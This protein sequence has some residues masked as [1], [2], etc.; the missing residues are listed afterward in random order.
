MSG[1][2]NI[3]HLALLKFGIS[4]APQQ[5]D[6]VLKLIKANPAYKDDFE[7]IKSSI[8]TM[9]D[10]N[11]FLDVLIVRVRSSSILILKLQISPKITK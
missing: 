1:T 10:E 8:T 6:E 7:K 4:V 5:R 3:E 9:T 2:T 11:E